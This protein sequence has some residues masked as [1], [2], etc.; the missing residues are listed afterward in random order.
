MDLK[1][2]S[3]LLKVEDKKVAVMLAFSESNVGHKIYHAVRKSLPFIKGLKKGVNRSEFAFDL[4]Q[5]M[6]NNGIKLSVGQ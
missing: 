5:E 4:I 1:F 2:T 6:R 3:G